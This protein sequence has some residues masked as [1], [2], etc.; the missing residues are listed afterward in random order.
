MTICGLLRDTEV[1]AGIRDLLVVAPGIGAWGVT[2]GVAMAN[3]GMSPFEILLMSIFVFAGSSQ[4]AA[5]P[6]IAAGAPLWVILS[7]AICVNLRFVV[8]SAHLRDYVMHHGLA[9]RLLLGY[10]T[11]DLNYVF[12]I[13]RFARPGRTPEERAA[14]DA[15][16]MANGWAGWLTWTGT[17]LLGVA[18]GASIPPSWGLEF[19]GI[20]ALL[21]ILSSLLTSGLRL[22]AAGIAGAAAVASYAL[23]LKLNIV[24]AIAAAVAITLPLDRG[25]PAVVDG[26]GG[27]A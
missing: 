22:L 7:T 16:W 23:P 2:T 3:S 1:R 14:I 27:R 11:A 5:L 19:A 18:L 4:L 25:R 24:V 6:L 26:D 8:F 17:S 10:L 21:G 12:L 9:R 13:K 20:L 15:Y